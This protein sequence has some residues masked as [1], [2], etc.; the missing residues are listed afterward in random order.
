MWFELERIGHELVEIDGELKIVDT[1]KTPD[2]GWETA[3]LTVDKEEI[4]GQYEE[5]TGDTVSWDE[6]EEGE[7]QY[8]A[9]YCGCWIVAKNYRTRKQAEKGHEKFCGR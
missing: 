6:L 4:I 1:V 7:I 8:Y 5:D 2:T 3:I 9:E